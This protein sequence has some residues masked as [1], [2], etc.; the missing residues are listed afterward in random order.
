M[1][2]QRKQGREMKEIKE[3]SMERRY[4]ERRQERVIGRKKKVEIKEG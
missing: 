1:Q 4:K 3:G 2:K